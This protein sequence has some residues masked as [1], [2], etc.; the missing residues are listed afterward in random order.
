MTMLCRV[1][2]TPMT[3]NV[4]TVETFDQSLCSDSLVMQKPTSCRY[5]Y[6]FYS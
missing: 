5:N 2:M 6:Y 4:Q 3:W 1:E